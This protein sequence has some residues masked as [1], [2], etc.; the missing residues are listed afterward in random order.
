MRIVP[1]TPGEDASSPAHPDHARWVKETT[2]AIEVRHA[3]AIGG[4]FRDAESENNRLLERMEALARIE[5]PKPSKP[6]G[7][8]KS[9]EQ[10]ALDRA[11]SVKRALPEVKPSAKMPPCKFCGGC[12]HCRRL[13]RMQAIRNKAL[14]EK[15]PWA[16]TVMWRTA[17]LLL[18]ANAAAG[19]FVGKTKAEIDRMVT[20]SA[21]SICDESVKVMGGWR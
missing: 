18:R 14:Q 3:Q 20:Q 10:R 9:R 21:E 16:T 4:T 6:T 17:L 2:L 1:V 15:D 7:P 5:K 13:I 12:L 11:V 8:R 19:E